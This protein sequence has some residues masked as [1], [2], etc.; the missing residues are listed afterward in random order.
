MRRPIALP[1]AVDNSDRS[2]KDTN[3]WLNTSEYSDAMYEVIFAV[4]SE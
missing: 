4:T 2:E 3:A 1:T